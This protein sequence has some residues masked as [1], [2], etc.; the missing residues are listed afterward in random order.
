MFFSSFYMVFIVCFAENDCKISDFREI[1]KRKT[2][3]TQTFFA[4]FVK[5]RN[6]APD[7]NKNCKL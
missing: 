6:F 5:I 7:F 4:I 1:S 2:Q 3:K